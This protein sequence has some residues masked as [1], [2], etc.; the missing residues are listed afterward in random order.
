VRPT[1]FV[2][3]KFIYYIKEKGNII[4]GFF[5]FFYTITVNNQYLNLKFID[6]TRQNVLHSI[7]D[8]KL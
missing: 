4:Y 7:L 1:E 5:F 2:I 6:Y 3:D 8:S